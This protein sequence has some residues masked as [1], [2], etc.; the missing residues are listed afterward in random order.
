VGQARSQ[1]FEAR[2]QGRAAHLRAFTIGGRR[3]AGVLVAP[4]ATGCAA[5]EA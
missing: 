5:S 2:R 3:R 4:K 1:F